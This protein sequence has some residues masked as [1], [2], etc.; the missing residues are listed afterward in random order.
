MG[1]IP[2]K[3]HVMAM[4]AA[5]GSVGQ[6]SSTKSPRKAKKTLKERCPSPILSD[7]H[8]PWVVGHSIVSVRQVEGGQV[9]LSERYD[10][11][12]PEPDTPSTLV[13]ESDSK[14]Q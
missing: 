12:P 11:L 2:S 4:D 6:L 8:P 13:G 3:S 9:I 10:T 14:E 5:D 1:C 7:D